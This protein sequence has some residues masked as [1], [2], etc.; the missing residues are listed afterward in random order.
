V[1]WGGSEP[2]DE[3]TKFELNKD[4]FQTRM[5]PDQ[6]RSL[7]LALQ[8]SAISYETFYFN[9]MNGGMTRP[10]VSA[11]DEQNQIDAETPEPIAPEVDPAAPVDPDA[12]PAPP[13]PG[14]PAPAPTPLPPGQ[15]KPAQGGGK[16]PY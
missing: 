6:L 2:T 4:F 8:A 16:G 15:K 7:V 5:T 13:V 1:W 12:P 3:D 9:L 14:A 10:D 11:E